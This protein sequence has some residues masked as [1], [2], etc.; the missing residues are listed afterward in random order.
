MSP[1]FSWIGELLQCLLGEGH[2]QPAA[3]RPTSRERPGDLPMS[4]QHLLVILGT[5]QTL[6]VGAK[7]SLGISRNVLISSCFFE[8]GVS[9]HTVK[10]HSHFL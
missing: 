6:A 3:P 8:G 2:V 1:G 5:G 9:G 10:V 4:A 7:L